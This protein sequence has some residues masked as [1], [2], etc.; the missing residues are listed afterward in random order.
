LPESERWRTKLSEALQA[1]SGHKVADN[2]G[3]VPLEREKILAWRKQALVS[4][5]STDF[6]RVMHWHLADRATRT[7]SPFS[8]ITVPVFIER[9]IAWALAHPADKDRNLSILG[10]AY[11][12]DPAHPLILLAMSVAEDDSETKALWKSLSFPRFNKDP[13]LS[14][15][16][17]EI[18][19]QD[20]DPE[21]AR[22]AAQIALELPSAAAADKAKAQAVLDRINPPSSSD[23]K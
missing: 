2:G 18:L 14:A 6:E 4:P 7:I 12:L 17:A 21:N 16:A 20:K 11:N 19:L 10:G 22:K 13:R 9:E 5:I 8:E 3:I 23:T 1:L 15:R